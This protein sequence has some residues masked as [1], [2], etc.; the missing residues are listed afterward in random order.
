[1]DIYLGS[2]HTWYVPGPNARVRY[3]LGTDVNTPFLQVAELNLGMYKVL[4]L[5]ADTKVGTGPLCTR[6][7]DNGQWTIFVSSGQSTALFLLLSSCFKMVSNR[8]KWSNYVHSHISGTQSVNTTPF[9]ACTQALVPGHPAD[10]P[11][12]FM[13]KSSE[14][15]PCYNLGT[16]MICVYQKRGRLVDI[17]G[18]ST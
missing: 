15:H 4:T 13:F 17:V 3:S 6:T 1:M 16:G 2:V 8:V 12:E 14:P 7:M 10:S 18:S 5:Y 9:C 11:V